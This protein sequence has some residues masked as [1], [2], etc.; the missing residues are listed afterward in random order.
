MTHDY[1]YIT[2]ILLHI[3]ETTSQ[4]N[5]ASN[6]TLGVVLGVVIPAIFVII[7]VAT[8]AIVATCK[9]KLGK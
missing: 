7:I 2:L 9:I 6:L 8:V 5:T 3:L 1:Y 4:A